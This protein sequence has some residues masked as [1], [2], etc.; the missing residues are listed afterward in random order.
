MKR[1]H[2]AVELLDL[3]IDEAY[4]FARV[5]VEDFNDAGREPTLRAKR[6]FREYYNPDDDRHFEQ[7]LIH[8][9]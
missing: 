5:C 4:M 3:H 8:N 7:P 1:K 6:K 9:I 2:D